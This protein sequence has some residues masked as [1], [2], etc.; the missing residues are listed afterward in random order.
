MVVIALVAVHDLVG[1]VEGA[2]EVVAGA[3]GAVESIYTCDAPPHLVIRILVPG[4]VLILSA[5]T[6][7]AALHAGHA[8]RQPATVLLIL[9]LACVLVILLQRHM[10]ADRH[11]SKTII[12]PIEIHL[13]EA[14]PCA[15][16][17]IC[18]TSRTGQDSQIVQ[19]PFLAL[20]QLALA[21]LQRLHARQLCLS[22]TSQ[23]ASHIASSHNLR[24]IFKQPKPPGTS[25]MYLNIHCQ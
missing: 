12:M 15:Y 1:P 16:L 23:N 20:K 5:L 25:T 24:L 4:D 8:V 21:D 7:C 11:C 13:W 22:S 18:R 6:C 19:E 10:L 14:C 3:F 9:L 17:P 2:D